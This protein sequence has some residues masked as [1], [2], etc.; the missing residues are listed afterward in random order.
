MSDSRSD[1]GRMSVEMDPG[2]RDSLAMQ[3]S[4]SFVLV[5]TSRSPC[6]PLSLHPYPDCTIHMV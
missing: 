5:V 1:S 2:L 6:K 4:L 3:W